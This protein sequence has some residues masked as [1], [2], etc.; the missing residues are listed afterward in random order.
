MTKQSVKLERLKNILGQMGSVLVAYS[1]GVDSTLLLKV[2]HDTLCDRVLAVTADSPTYPAQ[3]LDFA[4]KIAGRL[5]VRH[6]IIKTQELKD[7]N[8]IANPVNR[9]YFCKRE[10]F[11]RLKKIAGQAQLNFVLDA[12]NVDDEKDYRPG[13]KTKREF[14]VRSPLQEAGLGKDDI[15]KLSKRL[16]LVTWDKPSFACLASRISYGI[17]ITPQL[18][19]RINIAEVYL[20]KIGFRQVRFRHYNGLCR[21]EVLKE[22][23]PRLIDRREKIAKKLRELGYSYVTVDLEGYRSGSMNTPHFP[24][25][26]EASAG[27]RVGNKRYYRRKPVEKDKR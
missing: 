26:A 1:G 5:G 2:A 11:S 12:S 7:K 13:N 25:Y 19:T 22:D 17:K 27:R 18:L 14:K 8:F 3:E 15:R 20:R 10:L 4:Q 9:C 23:V 16:R 21:I 24:A 6:K